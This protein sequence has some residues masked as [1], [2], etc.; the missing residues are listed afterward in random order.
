MI[1]TKNKV[2]V[3]ELCNNPN[4]F[5]D[6]PILNDLS[7]RE[8]V[9]VK[10]WLAYGLD[11]D[12]ILSNPT[13]EQLTEK[14]NQLFP[15]YY[16]PLSSIIINNWGIEESKLIYELNKEF[17]GTWNKKYKPWSNIKRINK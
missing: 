1:W 15:K 11:L 16:T 4:A 10:D 8:L 12:F 3:I 6:Y 9:Y 2:M 5:N 13:S 7:E 14:C 17:S